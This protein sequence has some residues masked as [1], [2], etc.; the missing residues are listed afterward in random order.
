MALRNVPIFIQKCRPRRTTVIIGTIVLC[1][2]LITLAAPRLLLAPYLQFQSSHTPIPVPPTASTSPVAAFPL[3]V[4]PRTKTVSESPL[5]GHYLGTI[6]ASNHTSPSLAQNWFTKML[7]RLADSDWYQNLASPIS[8]LLIIQS[9]ERQ[10]EITAHFAHILGWSPEE[11]AAFRARLATEIPVL[12]DGKLYPGNYVVDKEATPETVAAVVAD[13]F[14]TEVR[15]HYTNDIESVIPMKDTLIVASLLEREAYDFDDMRYISGIIWNRLFINMRL[16]IDA[17]MQY[18]KASKL[19]N[20]GVHDWWPTPLP[21]DK[22]I[23]SP[24]NTYKNTGLPPAPIANPSIDAI[25]AAL[26]PRKTDC[27]FYFHDQHG[28]FYCTN[29]YEEHIALLKQVYGNTAK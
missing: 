14:N 9:G 21:A 27:L 5:V 3:G 20:P 11:Q 2:V 28:K 6:V 1:G 12:P 25:I 13:K 26:N 23:D 24:Y 8:R 29:T 7:A 17:T 4:N 22:F 16:Q 18:A 19:K 15:A 10:E